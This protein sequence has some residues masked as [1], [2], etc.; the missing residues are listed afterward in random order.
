[1]KRRKTI[2][3]SLL[4]KVADR[5]ADTDELAAFEQWLQADARHRAY[6]ERMSKFHAGQPAQPLDTDLTF[7]E[8]KTH[9]RIGPHRRTYRL[10]SA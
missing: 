10:G 3:L 4:R 7:A 1:M 5:T 6:Y 9:P 2:E 8:L